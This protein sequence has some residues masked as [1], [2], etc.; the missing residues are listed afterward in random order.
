M[1]CAGDIAQAEIRQAHGIDLPQGCCNDFL[2][3]KPLIGWRRGGA[4]SRTS[5]HRCISSSEQTNHPFGP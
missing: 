2:F 5:L 3:R 4:F 1:E